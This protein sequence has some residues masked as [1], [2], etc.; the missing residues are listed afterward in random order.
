[1]VKN[2]GSLTPLLAAAF[3]ALTESA[4]AASGYV[5]VELGGLGGGFASAFAVNAGGRAV[6]V[7]YT[8]LGNQQIRASSWTRSDGMVELGTLGGDDSFATAVN[9]SDQV[10]GYSSVRPRED[11]THAFLWTEAGGM[12]DLGT[13]GGGFSQ[14]NAVNASGQVVGHSSLHG[15]TEVHPFSWTQAGGMIDLGTLGG[16]GSHASA[17][18]DAGQVVGTSILPG[19]SAS[20]AF[21]WTGVGRDDRPGGTERRPEHRLCGEPLGPH[22]RSQLHRLDRSARRAVAATTLRGVEKA[23]ALADGC[24]GPSDGEGRGEARSGARAIAARA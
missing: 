1:M 13:L 10:V 19:G 18:N 2:T 11:A 12:I 4:A 3:V 20:H 21:S 6:G 24:D 15:S 7:S 8:V 22:R 16:S 17:L 9:D 14:A 23:P 5:L